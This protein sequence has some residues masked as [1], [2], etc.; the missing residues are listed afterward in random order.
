MAMESGTFDYRN[1][2]ISR[3]NAEHGSDMVRMPD[4]A[5]LPHRLADRGD[6][7]W[8]ADDDRDSESAARLRE[9]VTRMDDMCADV[10]T[11]RHRHEARA[12]AAQ[13]QAIRA[14]TQGRD[15]ADGVA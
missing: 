14:I 6:R 3:M 10:L 15:I 13:W 2:D 1:T 11:Y 12:L 5:L 9:L 8:L 7:G 4:G